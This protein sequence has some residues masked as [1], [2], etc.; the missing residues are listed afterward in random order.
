MITEKVLLQPEVIG[1]L[2]CFAAKN[3]DDENK[4]QKP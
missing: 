3:W 1:L 4:L 2:E